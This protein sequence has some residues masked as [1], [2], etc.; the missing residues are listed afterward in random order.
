MLF[1][2]QMLHCKATAGNLHCMSRKCYFN[3]SD[4]LF[5]V[6]KWFLVIQSFRLDGV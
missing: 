3:P 4:V 5:I 2:C 1:Y 6:V